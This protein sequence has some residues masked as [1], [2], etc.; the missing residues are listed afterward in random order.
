MISA[1]RRWSVVVAAM[2]ALAIALAARASFARDPS[3]AD[4]AKKDEARTHFEL[5]LTHFDS[6]EWAAALAE[7]KRSLEL[8][9]TRAAAK[10]A[11]ICLKKE[12]R[13][14]EALDMFE[15]VARSFPDLSPVDRE[16]VERETASLRPFVGAL[17]VRSA[18]PGA[19]VI[20]DGRERGTTPLTGPA[21]VAVGSHVVRVFKEGFF[22]FEARVDVAGGQTARVDAALHALTR[23]GRLRVVEE[24]GLGLDVL[25]D[26]AVVGRTPWEGALAAGEHTIALRGADGVGTQPA[27]AKVEVDGTSTLSLRAEPLDASLRVT[28]TPAGATVAVDGVVVGR[29]IWEGPLRAGRHRV[30]VGAEGFLP[31]AQEMMLA[32]GQAPT[33]S[34]SL[35]RDPSSPLWKKANPPH[36]GLELVGGFGLAPVY[37]GD[38]ARASCDGCTSRVAVGGFAAFRGGYELGS[39]IAFTIDAGYLRVGESVTRAA[40]LKPVGRPPNAGTMEDRLRLGG[41]MLGASAGVHRGRSL[42]F[43]LRL[44]AGVFVGTG[45]DARHGDFVN[46]AGERYP[47]DAAEAAPATYAYLAPEVRLG[48]RLGRHLEIGAGLT[49]IVLLAL[50]QPAWRD[51][52][53]VTT[54]VAPSRGDG[55][56]TFGRESMAGGA[57]VVLAPGIGARYDF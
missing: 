13:Y 21:R 29:G 5:G 20:V 44:G 3:A 40:S 1:E 57:V 47:V 19:R 18:E 28:P 42:T 50:N 7:F 11:A 38:V 41:A 32:R 49:A 54:G 55:L 6:G 36:V 8:F 27:A 25:V 37:G 30:E 9:P 46:G 12:K 39:G 35:E 26:G 14:D 15:S 45:R 4:S 51:A 56:A 23:S 34:V 16:L 31:F 22:P 33:L 24:A 10:D 43:T 53:A 2:L 48:R 17:D 52:N